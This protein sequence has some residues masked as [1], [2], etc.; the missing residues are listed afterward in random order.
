MICFFAFR[1]DIFSADVWGK[2]NPNLGSV[3]NQVRNMML[4]TVWVFVGIEGASI[5]SARAEKRSDVL[6]R[7]D[8]SAVAAHRTAGEQQVL[9]GGLV[10]AVGQQARRRRRG[11]WTPALSSGVSTGSR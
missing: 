2:S 10:D 5:F 11:F 4:V 6:D 9:G 1:L 8:D 7:G 3:M